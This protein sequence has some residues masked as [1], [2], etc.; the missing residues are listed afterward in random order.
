MGLELTIPREGTETTKS[1]TK[2]T[3]FFLLELTIPRKGTNT[4]SFI[5]YA[6]VNSQDFARAGL[7]SLSFR[8]AL[9]LLR[10]EDL[11]LNSKKFIIFETK[12]DLHDA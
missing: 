1:F 10:P 2:L 5:F 8:Q 11:L 12:P 4:Q 7:G 6:A 9:Y 3:A